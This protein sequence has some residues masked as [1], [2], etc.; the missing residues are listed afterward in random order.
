MYGM[1]R[2]IIYN[3]DFFTL[4]YRV[5]SS[6]V[7]VHKKLV[8][9]FVFSNNP[10]N[11]FDKKKLSETMAI[12]STRKADENS[13]DGKKSTLLF[14]PGIRIQFLRKSMV[15]AW[16][17]G[18]NWFAVGYIGG[19]EN[20]ST[21]LFAPGIRIQ[22]IKFLRNSMEVPMGLLWYWLNWRDRKGKYTPVR[23]WYP[24]TNFN[25]FKKFDG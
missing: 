19:E 13:I 8:Y 2:K 1:W 18:S 14:D 25:I 20:E 10:K 6:I 3:H 9:C 11:Y 7:I 17:Q 4:L 23:S 12:W 5:G 21:L 22:I 24:D 16:F 15:N